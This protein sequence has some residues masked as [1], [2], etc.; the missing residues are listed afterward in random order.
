MGR[1]R[2]IWIPLLFPAALFAETLRIDLKAGDPKSVPGYGAA[3]P[4]AVETTIPRLVFDTPRF[5]AK[6]PLFLRIA[7]GGTKDVPFFCALDRSTDSGLHDLLHLDRDRDLDLTNDGE[8]V[9]GTVREVLGNTLVEFTAIEVAVPYA[10]DGKEV[11]EPYRLAIFYFAEAGKVPVTVQVE[12]DGWR[13]GTATFAGKPVEVALLDDDSDGQFTSGDSWAAG[14]PGS[15]LLAREATRS[16]SHPCWA[17]GGEQWLRVKEVDPAG[18]FV[19]VEVAPAEEKEHDY[20]LRIARARQTPEERELGIDPMRPKADPKETIDWLVD[21]PVARG[22]EIGEKVDKPLLV[23]FF[24]PDC[25]WCVRMARYTFRDR[26]V[27]NLCDRYVC[28]RVLFGPASD[29]TRKYSVEGTPTYVIFGKDGKEIARQS[30]FLAP[31]KFAE[32]LKKALR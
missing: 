15:P 19:T 4:V 27:V 2:W 16:M 11:R 12:R 1:M 29:D 9:R 8:P 7:L 32:W 6:D 26:E 31:D 10:L 22:L 24:A 20:W 14:E 17:P 23:E 18:R 3:R 25:V 13:S 21:R 28:Q 30:G 5:H